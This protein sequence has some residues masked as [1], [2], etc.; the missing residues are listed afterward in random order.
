MMTTHHRKP[1]SL[2]GNREPKNITRLP[3][4]IHQAWHLLFS[5]LSP[6]RIAEEINKKY[7]D[8]DYEFVVRRKD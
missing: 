6:D 4:K 8:P 7:L 1:K 3:H 5:A 2:G